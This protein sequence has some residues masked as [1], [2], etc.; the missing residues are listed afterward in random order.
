MRSSVIHVAVKLASDKVMFLN[1]KWAGTQVHLSS[2]SKVVTPM[3][4]AP[5]RHGRH[6]V[7]Q[8]EC[9]CVS[10]TGAVGAET[11]QQLKANVSLHTHGAGVD[12]EDVCATLI[13]KMN[14]C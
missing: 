4:C 6:N 7:R 13:H 14:R 1:R 8:C 11:S 2:T 5:V 9:C 10:L 3:D 12:L